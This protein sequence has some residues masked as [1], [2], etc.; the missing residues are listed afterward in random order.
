MGNTEANSN[1]G[2][3]FAN[4]GGILDCDLSL[5]TFTNS[6]VITVVKAFQIN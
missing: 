1:L 2:G 5:C 3:T 4:H 6:T